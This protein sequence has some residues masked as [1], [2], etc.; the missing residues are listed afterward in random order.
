ML[1]RVI[2]KGMHIPN[3]RVHRYPHAPQL[4]EDMK[5]VSM[6]WNEV[7]TVGHKNDVQGAQCCAHAFHCES[8]PLVVLVL[9]MEDTWGL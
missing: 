2:N 4:Q 6:K 5:T 3:L 1:V 9:H 8:I 7:L